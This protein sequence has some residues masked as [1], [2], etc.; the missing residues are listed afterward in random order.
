MGCVVSV[1]AYIKGPGHDL[2]VERFRAAE[3]LLRAQQ[4]QQS[5]AA[6][7]I[8]QYAAATRRFNAGLEAFLTR[9]FVK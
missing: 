7:A 2:A 5:G 9:R 1:L 6:D 4:A 8:E 3:T